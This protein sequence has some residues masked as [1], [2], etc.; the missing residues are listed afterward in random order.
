MNLEK[1]IQ[2]NGQ[3]YNIILDKYSTKPYYEVNTKDKTIKTNIDD[4][5]RVICSVKDQYKRD[6]QNI[7]K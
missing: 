1:E 3:K 7:Y 4:L 2:L 6:Q 5:E